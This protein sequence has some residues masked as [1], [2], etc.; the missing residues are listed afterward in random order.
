MA[1]SVRVLLFVLMLLSVS[2]PYSSAQAQTGTPQF[3]SYAGGPDVVN[4]A[5]LNVEF[6][7]PVINKPGR[8]SNYSYNL[9]YDS[10]VW[11]PA[12]SNGTRSWV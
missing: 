3:G 11:Q 5:N 9:V 2:S 4:L 12:M 10:S 1:R 8:G 6:I 7:V